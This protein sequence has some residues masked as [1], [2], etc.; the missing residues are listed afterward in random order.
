MRPATA[1]FR[2]VDGIGSRNFPAPQANLM[3]VLI[4]GLLDQKLPWGLVLIGAAIAVFIELLT[5]HSLTFAVGVY[6]PLSSTMPIFIGGLVRKFADKRYGRVPDDAS[7]SEGTLLSSG[8][9]AGGALVGVLVA[10]LHFPVFGL[11]FDEDLDLPMKIALGPRFWPGLFGSDVLPL[12]AFAGLAISA[13][14]GSERGKGYLSAAAR[15]A[16]SAAC[17]SSFA[18]SAARRAA[19]RFSEPARRMSGLPSIERRNRKSCTAFASTR[20]VSRSSRATA[21]TISGFCSSRSSLRQVQHGRGFAVT[22]HHE[23][24]RSEH[25]EMPL[26]HALELRPLLHDVQLRRLEPESRSRDA[27]PE[28]LGDLEVV[29]HGAP[30]L[31]LREKAGSELLLAMLEDLERH[32]DLLAHF[33]SHGRV[34]EREGRRI[35]HRGPR[36]PLDLARD[37]SHEGRAHTESLERTLRG[38]ALRLS[39]PLSRPGGNPERPECP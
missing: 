16:V 37:G 15:G 8:L 12:A 1:V 23:T 4:S 32:E 13:V 26:A 39:R 10:F 38:D 24:G 19:S 6:L 17:A 3:A 34:D 25:G 20:V 22:V 33:A 2:R 21:P 9:I 31:D 14:S 36:L 35:V 28:D 30:F 7:E 11:G 29:G 27:R 18:M 5:G